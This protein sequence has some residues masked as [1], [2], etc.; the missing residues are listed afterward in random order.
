VD[1]EGKLWI[2]DA[3]TDLIGAGMTPVDAATMDDVLAHL[4]QTR[5]V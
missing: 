1:Y 4:S 3:F 2:T 5:K